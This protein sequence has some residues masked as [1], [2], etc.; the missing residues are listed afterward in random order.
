M[1]A[2]LA[3]IIWMDGE[4]MDLYSNPLEEYFLK[5]KKKRPSFFS[6]DV[7]RRGY[8]ATWEVRDGQLF[9]TKLEG[10]I[11]SN[12]LFS[13]KVKKCNLSTLFRKPGPQGVKA[14]WFSGKLRVPN[15]KM[16]QY[17]DTGYDSRFEREIILTV[18][19]GDVLKKRTLD[20]THRT[21]VVQEIANII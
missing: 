12:S 4:K 1:A 3:D 5:R 18:E 15:G 10:D 19:H 6:L 8:V 14:E 16:T 11:E 20:Y 21:L 2:Q 7:C 13:K 17:E 9:L